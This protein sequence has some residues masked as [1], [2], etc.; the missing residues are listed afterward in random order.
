MA[1]VRAEITGRKPRLGG[2]AETRIPSIRGPPAS[3][4]IA[5]YSLPE[6]AEAHRF[7]LDFLFKLLR[8]GLGPDTMKVGGRTLVSIEAAARWRA[9][10]ETATRESKEENAEVA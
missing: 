8:D 7:S 1:R 3:I 6:F 2:E 9:E 4:P 10:R 5:A